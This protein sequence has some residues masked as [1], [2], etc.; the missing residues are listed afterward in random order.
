MYVLALFVL[1]NVP[2]LLRADV[3]TVDVCGRLASPYLCTVIEVEGGMYYLQNVGGFNIGDYVRVIGTVECY[4]G[5]SPCYVTNCGIIHNSISLCNT[6]WYIKPDGSGDHPTIQAGIDASVD[7]YTIL[8]ANGIF[9]G[10]GNRNIDYHGK[11]ITVKSSWGNPNTCIIDCEGSEVD[12]HRGFYFHSGEGPESVLQGVTITNGYYGG[13]GGVR[14]ENSTPT[15]TNCKFSGNS[16][17][18]NGGGMYC[19]SS[20]PLLTNCT[21]SGN[22]DVSTLDGGGMYCVNSSPTLTNCMFLENS[23]AAYG[24]GISCE[25]GSSPTLTNCTISGNSASSGGGVYSSDYS[26]PTLEKTIIAFST[27][28]DAVY[29]DGSSS[30]TLNCCDVSG[31]AGGD[32][33]G[34]IA[35]QNDINDNF[36]LDPLFC[37]PPGSG[38]VSLLSI[39]PC[40]PPRSPCGTLIGALPVGCG[41][42]G[43]LVQCPSDSIVP[44]FS[45]TFSL[46]LEGF[47]ITNIAPI[48]LAFDYYLVS[49]GPATLVD[50]GD[51]N[52]LSGTTQVL[53][54]GESISP[55]EASLDIPVI[56]DYLQEFVTYYVTAVGYPEIINSCLTMIDFEPGLEPLADSIIVAWGKNEYGE[57]N[58]PWP[59]AGFVA[60]AAGRHH[61]LGVKSDG[62]VVA[63]GRNLEGQCDVPP[64]NAGFVGILGGDWHSLGLK[65]DGTIVAWGSN[66]YG[67][68]NVPSPNAGFVGIA[69]GGLHSLGLKSDGTI[70]AWG[71][72]EYGQCDVPSPN[73]GFIAVAGGIN[74][75]LGLKSDGTIVAWGWNGYGQCDL[76][77]PNADF[78]AVAGAYKHSLGLKSDGTI[79]AWGYNYWGQCNVPSPNAGF[80][81]IGGRRSHSLGLKSDGTIV[82]WGHNGHGQCNVPLPNADFIAVAGGG[83][84]N[85][86]LKSFGPSVLSFDIHPR[87]CPNPFNIKW[88]ENINKG[89]GNDK[90]KTKK[91][92]VMPAAI[93]GSERFDVTEIDIS[94]LLLEGVQ[95]L[96]SNLED[97]TRPVSSNAA[98]ACTTGSPDGFRD[99][100]LKFSRPEIAAVIGPAEVEDVVELTLTGTLMDGTPF[101]ASDCVTIVGNRDDLPSLASGDEVVLKPAVPNPF[102]PV[103]RI[104]YY[105]PSDEFVN[106]SIFDVTGK[107]VQELIEQQQPAGEHVIEW[108]AGG[109]PSGVYFY[110]LKA[111][112]KVLTKKMVLLK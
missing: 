95:P 112:G 42:T 59:N 72:N 80:I 45:N 17:P 66:G 19:D 13:G 79:V 40:A 101:E 96:R 62:T 3:A 21:F 6:A 85:L 75:S 77:P 1:S 71:N 99:L 56:R 103:T 108:N 70:V 91:G 36:S 31:N 105:I 25:S 52:S 111:G 15:F 81:A 89:K 18:S 50:N 61:S 10:H 28:G 46:V 8:L 12:P 35:D 7:G 64:P 57:L 54:P 41:V 14:C 69:G 65:S 23:T 93:V 22:G 100:T 76:P 24:G 43:Q 11:A 94:T 104:S 29:C 44:V 63:W 38:N 48:D 47:A 83:H 60:V 37:G 27:Q 55:P 88:L 51:P 97:V 33:V 5:P 86:G 78:I 109:M 67:Q 16:T 92:G 82:A 49:E 73:A 30:A 107:L 98:C 74:H 34:C 53:S 32:W 102:N 58:V 26:S 39:S 68:C 2:R 84:H 90:T 110:R 4:S 9:S 87:S 20:N 106:L